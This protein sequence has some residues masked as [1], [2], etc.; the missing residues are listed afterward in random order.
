MSEM[1]RFRASGGGRYL[2]CH[3]M[4]IGKEQRK[5]VE[6]SIHPALFSFLSFNYFQTQQS[7]GQDSSWTKVG[8]WSGVEDELGE[9]LEVSSAVLISWRA[10]G[11]GAGVATHGE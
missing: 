10:G 3:C 11:E 4:I 8:I 6:A 1:S 7:L 2:S 5:W 9:L